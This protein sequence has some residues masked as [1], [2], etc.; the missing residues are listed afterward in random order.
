MYYWCKIGP[1]ENE[2]GK[3]MPR[4]LSVFS[5]I[6]LAVRLCMYPDYGGGAHFSEFRRHLDWVNSLL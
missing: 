3:R 6:I 4:L 1:S 2:V 5:P